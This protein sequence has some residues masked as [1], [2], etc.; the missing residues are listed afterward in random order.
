MIFPYLSQKDY[1]YDISISGR[2]ITSQHLSHKD[3]RYDISISGNIY[4]RNINQLTY[5][6]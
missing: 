3:Y 1:G 4:D 5:N 6:S 2:D